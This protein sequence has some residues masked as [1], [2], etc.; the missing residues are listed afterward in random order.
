MQTRQAGPL[1]FL[2]KAG[3]YSEEQLE[4]DTQM[5]RS[6]LMEE[7]Y[8]DAKISK[9]QIFSLRRQEIFEY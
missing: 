1:S 7:G 8:A 3:N 9:P 2:G 4:M 5:L 6:A